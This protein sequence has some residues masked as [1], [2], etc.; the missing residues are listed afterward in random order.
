VTP[1]RPQFP[2]RFDMEERQGALDSKRG[3][4]GR[5]GFPRSPVN[6]DRRRKLAEC[7]WTSLPILQQRPGL[8]LPGF[9]P[10]RAGIRP[11]TGTAAGHDLCWPPSGTSGAF[12]G[13]AFSRG[14]FRRAGMAQ[15]SFVAAVRYPGVRS[16]A[17]YRTHRRPRRRIDGGSPT[18]LNT[19]RKPFGAGSVNS[20]LRPPC[21]PATDA[22]SLS[23]AA[24]PSNWS[25]FPFD[26]GLYDARR[27][28]AAALREA[29]S[30]L[31]AHGGEHVLRLRAPR[32][33]RAAKPL[34]DDVRSAFPGWARR[35][36]PDA[37]VEAACPASRHSRHIRQAT[38][39]RFACAT[40]SGP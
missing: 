8:E 26:V 32:S 35:S 30:N 27:N 15:F 11:L 22:I 37:V 20:R 5:R 1:P 19:P 29:A 4:R 23:R 12:L 7:E 13:N 14:T 40:A 25:H 2:N 17:S 3:T 33:H 16:T 24:V 39:E 18:D 38:P 6:F 9:V 10:L 28:P 34:I 36:D 31:G 21:Q